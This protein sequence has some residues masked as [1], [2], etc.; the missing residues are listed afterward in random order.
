MPTDN[1]NLYVYIY[2]FRSFN[3]NLINFV[4][5]MYKSKLMGIL[6]LWLSFFDILATY[7]PEQNRQNTRECTFHADAYRFA[8]KPHDVL[9]RVAMTKH[10]ECLSVISSGTSCP[11]CTNNV[12]WNGMRLLLLMRRFPFSELNEP[13][14]TAN[15]CITCAKIMFKSTYIF[16]VVKINSNECIITEIIGIII[17]HL[18][19]IY[20]IIIKLLYYI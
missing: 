17:L 10:C 16:L 8:N 6:T 20:Y 3:L 1:H 4:I 13:V 15:F 7:C 2:I 11:P 9:C 19:Y 12:P 5:N 18:L 14:M